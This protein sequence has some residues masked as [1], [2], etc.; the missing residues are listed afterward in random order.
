VGLRQT[1]RAFLT[2]RVGRRAK[3]VSVSALRDDF[4]AQMPAEDRL[5]R[6]NAFL[7]DEIEKEIRQWLNQ[8]VDEQNK[9]LSF[10]FIREEPDSDNWVNA[11]PKI[12]M[13]ET[14]LSDVQC[15]LNAAVEADRRYVKKKKAIADRIEARA[16]F[17]SKH[18][19]AEGNDALKALLEKHKAKQEQGGKA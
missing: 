19:G 10:N 9:Q 11:R 17:I 16:K 14:L 2:K 8:P 4:K 3:K 5:A 7:D 13:L 15:A 1:I 6:G 18:F 12:I